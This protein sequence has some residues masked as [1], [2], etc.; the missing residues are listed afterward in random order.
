VVELPC[1]GRVYCEGASTLLLSHLQLE[2]DRSFLAFLP[3]P[4]II[5]HPPPPSSLL[6]YLQFA[7]HT[8]VFPYSNAKRQEGGGADEFGVDSRGQL[9]LV[10]WEKFGE[11]V[12]GMEGFVAAQV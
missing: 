8:H 3:F 4:P 7:T 9:M 1:G 10:P 5:F 11:I 6:F 12:E 2:T